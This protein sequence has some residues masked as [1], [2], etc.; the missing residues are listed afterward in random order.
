MLIN[1]FKNERKNKDRFQ[2]VCVSKRAAIK[3]K[4]EDEDDRETPTTE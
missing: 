1:K 3:R 4:I 2:P